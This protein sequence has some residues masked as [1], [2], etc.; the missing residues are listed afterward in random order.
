MNFLYN[1]NKNVK[2]LYKNKKK[3]LQSVKKLESEILYKSENNVK[4]IKV[5]KNVYTV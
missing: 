5:K 3:S 2:K 4:K 1:N